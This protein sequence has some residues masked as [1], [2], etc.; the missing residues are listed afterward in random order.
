MRK[1]RTGVMLMVAFS[2]L[3]N[4]TWA[5]AQR[6]FL[7]DAQVFD[8]YAS[9]VGWTV[10]VEADSIL[11]A[12]PSGQ[13]PRAESEDAVHSLPGK[14]VL[15][16]LIEGHSHFLLHPYD[17]TP[18]TDQVMLESHSERAIRAVN[19]A[20]STLKA[21]FTSVRDLGSEGA[22]YADV[23]IKTAIEKEIVPGPRMQVAG[24]AIV[25]TGSYGPKG[26]APHVPVPIGAQVADGASLE[27]VVRE[28]IGHGADVIKVY[29]DYRWG[30]GGTAMPTF[31]LEE[32]KTIVNTAALSGRKVVAHAST[33]VGMELSAR[34]GVSTIEHGD[35]ATMEVLSLMKQYNVAL[36]PTLAAGDAIMQYRGWKKGIEEDPPRIINKKKSFALAI[37]SGVRICAGGDVGVFPHGDNIR[38]LLMME[39]YGMERIEVLRSVTSTNAEVLGFN[40]LGRL[41]KGFL[42]DIVVVNGN[43]LEDLNALRSP[44]HVYKDGRLY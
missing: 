42:A 11:Y 23:G 16:G 39:E 2:L 31:T 22:G 43:P 14:T 24:R 35:G 12:G 32:L 1:E 17:E 3:L 21:G 7:T 26:Y 13:A 9:R 10:V 37:E 44:L 41:R 19:H 8:G 4:P 36:C 40:R 34:A 30:P 5:S 28:Q 20:A 38:E 18:W 25:A 33:P 29:A 27:S 15:P 6:I